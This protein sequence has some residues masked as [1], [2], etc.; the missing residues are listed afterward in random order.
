MKSNTP[1]AVPSSCGCGGASP[2]PAGAPDSSRYWAH[3]NQG[4]ATSVCGNV[5]L[6]PIDCTDC[7]E[8]LDVL[9]PYVPSPAD[10]SAQPACNVIPN[11]N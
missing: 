10:M 1:F 2:T 9:P 4:S 11:A 6:S 3:S 8:A 7:C 5:A